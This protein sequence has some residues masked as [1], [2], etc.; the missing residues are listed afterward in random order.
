MYLPIL[1]II[2]VVIEAAPWGVYVM[3]GYLGPQGSCGCDDY[4]L[5]QQEACSASGSIVLE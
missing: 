1:Q 5:R 2:F 4:L 3:F